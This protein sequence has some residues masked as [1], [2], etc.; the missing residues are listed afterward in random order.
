MTKKIEN[1]NNGEFKC[2]FNSTKKICYHVA[3]RLF[4]GRAHESL[5]IFSI[6]LLSSFKYYFI[7]SLVT[8]Q[9]LVNIFNYIIIVLDFKSHSISILFILSRQS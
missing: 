2:C 8:I 5:I 6:T 1:L 4:N 7:Q 3:I 9:T